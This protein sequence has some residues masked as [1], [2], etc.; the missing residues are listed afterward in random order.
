MLLFLLAYDY[1]NKHRRILRPDFFALKY[2]F[3]FY[4]SP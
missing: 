1:S 3:K 4:V 2:N